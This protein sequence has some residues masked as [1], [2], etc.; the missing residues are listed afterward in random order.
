MQLIIL[1][2]HAIQDSRI[3]RHM[4]SVKNLNCK[5]VRI[6]IDHNTSYN[7]I[8]RYTGENEVYTIGIAH[9]R[10]R[11]LDALYSM[12]D[13]FIMNKNV[14]KTI[15]KLIK[16]SFKEPTILHVHDPALL[17]LAV[18]LSSYFQNHWIVYDRHEVYESRKQYCSCIYLPRIGRLV[19]IL[20]ASQIDGVV[21]IAD[22]YQNVVRRFF[23]RSDVAVVPNLPILD[24]YNRTAI[25]SKIENLSPSSLLQFVYIGSLNW[26]TDRDLELILYIAENLL[27]KQSNL[28]FIIGGA[29][30]DK[31][32]LLEFA[33]LNKAYPHNFIYTGYLSREKVIEY[34]QSAHFGFFL[35]RPDTDYWVTCS[36]NK[37][38]EYL[39]CGVIPIIRADC[40]YKEQLQ[41]VSLWFNR[42][43]SKE[44]ILNRIESLIIDYV[45]IQG[46]M[47]QAYRLGAYFSFNPV[48]SGYI[49]LYNTIRAKR[50]KT[51]EISF[52]EN[53]CGTL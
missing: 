4:Q 24:D 53:H 33:R 11:K 46:M 50:E 31:Q 17:L 28:K 15:L 52:S 2:Q 48:D 19:E 10:N 3:N 45:K 49:A 12:V 14:C 1:D 5:L 27:S 8:V 41:D 39:S 9:R 32:L 36:P 6:N 21:T 44:C 38:F 26:K 16:Y 51:S 20:V 34:T 42:E 25:L 35:I 22:E 13:L 30:T 23:P 47:Q 29:T 37:V 43:D 40:T 7:E 18:R